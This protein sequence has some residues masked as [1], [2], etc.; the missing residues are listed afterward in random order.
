MIASD[1]H[2]CLQERSIG[3][4]TKLHAFSM[5]AGLWQEIRGTKVIRDKSMR[6]PECHKEFWASCKQQKNKVMCYLQIP[7]LVL[8][9]DISVSPIPFLALGHTFFRGWGEIMIF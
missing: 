8:F 6:G 5:S 7:H 1:R 4:S 2:N 9:L 3:V